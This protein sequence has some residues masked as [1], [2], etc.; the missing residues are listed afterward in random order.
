MANA[1]RDRPTGTSGNQEAPP[2]VGRCVKPGERLFAPS[3]K[4]VR[5]SGCYWHHALSETLHAY[6]A[7][8]ECRV[9][10]HLREFQEGRYD[11]EVYIPSPQGLLLDAGQ[12]RELLQKVN[13]V[14]SYVLGDHPLVD[15]VSHS[16]SFTISVIT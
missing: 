12:C 5:I 1:R 8:Y 9:R 15:K 6:L 3:G 4:L 7:T 2:T 16:F 14:C 10:F 11:P 13:T